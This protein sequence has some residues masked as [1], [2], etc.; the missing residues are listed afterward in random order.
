MLIDW[1]TVAAQTINFLIL[2]WLLKRFLYKPILDAIDAREA[3]IAAEIADA[4]KKRADAKQ[5]RDEFEQKNKA[6]AKQREALLSQATDE[7]AAERQRLLTEARND[8]DVLA[9]KRRDELRA[10]QQS[11]SEEIIKR[12]QQE[13]FALTRKT[14]QDLADVSLEEQLTNVFITHLHSLNG[15]LQKELAAA[16]Q[17]P[18]QSPLVRSAFILPTEQQL[19][20]QTEL[21]ATM[22]ANVQIQF[23]VVPGLVSGIELSVNG[24]K[25]AWSLN[26]YLKELEVR[27]KR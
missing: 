14:L 21:N 11:L 25:L 12:T 20:I 24:K 22:S 15:E 1:F 27:T 26:D 16:L 18:K 8:A 19:K 4:N 23:E 6:F 3:R 10:E 17:T 5:E 9:A 2:V 7:A 13:V